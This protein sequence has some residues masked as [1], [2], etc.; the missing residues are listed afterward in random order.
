[1]GIDR[2]VPFY[3][4]EELKGVFAVSF[5]LSDISKFLES[6]K[7]GKSGQA[8]IFEQSGVLIGTSAQEALAIDNG[9]DLQVLNVFESTNPVTRQ[10][11]EYLREAFGHLGKLPPT[12][13][14]EIAIDG[15][16]HFLQVR[17]FQ[18][19][20]GLNWAI[21]IVIPEAD[22]MAQIDANTRTTIWL[23]LFALAIATLLGIYT[24]RWISQPI[25]HLRDASEAIASGKWERSIPLQRIDE[26]QDLASSFNRMS[27][28]L[29]TIFQ[30]QQESH[31]ELEE[32]RAFLRIV[33]DSAPCFI[34]VKDWHGRYLLA[35]QAFARFYG[36]TSDEIV[37]KTDA[38]ING[39][40]EEIAQFLAVDRQ[41]I[42]TGNP[43]L[44]MERAMGVEK[45][46]HH[47]QSIK[48][49]ILGKDS[50]NSQ[51]LGVATDI[52]DLKAA[53]LALQ[54]NE[55]KNRAILAAIPDRLFRITV[56]AIY[57]DD[58]N[59]RELE[60]NKSGII[61]S[62]LQV[63]R[64]I[65]DKIDVAEPP[66]CELFPTDIEERQLQAIRYALTTGTPQIYE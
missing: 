62:S 30:A 25:Q 26:L 37:G 66:I 15:R 23:C 65:P 9:E 29:K 56:D 32:Q 14:N 31:A 12:Y 41:V 52:S 57:L 4:G 60:T 38:D 22:F 17:K 27:K 47:F 21:A 64:L 55:T 35:N 40:T 33:I 24:S 1:M 43:Q 59:A 18:D 48:T 19:E 46:I 5:T 3:E 7:I 63:Q 42:T 61:I 11:V 6:L 16:R 53:E 28:Q 20:A 13:R 34:F 54:D 51:V 10:T 36:M 49:L 39:T 58:L 2:I 8:F 44:V 45:E 50:Q